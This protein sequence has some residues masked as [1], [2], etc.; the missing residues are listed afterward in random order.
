MHNFKPGDSKCVVHIGLHK[1]GSSS[2]QESLWRNL[3]DSR[4][5]YVCALDNQPNQGFLMALFGDGNTAVDLRHRQLGMSPQEIEIRKHR[6][7][8]GLECE[9]KRARG[10]TAIISAENFSTLDESSVKRLNSMLQNLAAPDSPRSVS[11]VAYIRPPKA[12]MESKFQQRLKGGL[13]ALYCSELFPRYD[14]LLQPYESIFGK[15][16]TQWWKYDP[17]NFPK[18]DVVLHF[19][20][21]LGVD[22][23]FSDSIRVND[24]LSLGAIKLLFCFNKHCF[25][26]K[27][28]QPHWGHQL[29]IDKLSELN[30]LKFKLQSS[31]VAGILEKGMS[32]TKWIETRLGE[33]LDEDIS[34]HDDTSIRHEDELLSPD[35]H[36]INW[37]YGLPEMSEEKRPSHPSPAAIA[38]ALLKLKTLLIEKERS[39]RRLLRLSA[40]VKIA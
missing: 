26:L 7:L 29:L 6:M 34:Q 14:Q 33:S 23:D 25:S 19:C 15:H 5:H 27:R 39:S 12:T 10:K 37:L 13:R 40:N 24:G 3:K 32:S 30:G 21:Q 18:G 31:L 38:E 1:T 11:A 2:I 9:L 20:N 4:F 28:G 35:A 22:F 8:S 16:G 17:N 36:A